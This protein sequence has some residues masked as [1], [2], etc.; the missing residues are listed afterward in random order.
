MV[1]RNRKMVT[2]LKLRTFLRSIYQSFWSKLHK[3]FDFFIL[4]VVIA[5]SELTY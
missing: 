4:H 1:E 2:V 5:F 3:F